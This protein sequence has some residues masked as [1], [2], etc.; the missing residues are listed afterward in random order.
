MPAPRLDVLTYTGIHRRLERD[1][2]K[3]SEFE[4]VGCGEPAQEWAYD[5]LDL[6]EA[7]RPLSMK[8]EHYHP[9]CI[10]CHRRFD[11]RDTCTKGHE[12]T[13]ENTYVYKGARQ[14]RRC[15][16]EAMRVLRSKR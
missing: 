10:S 9:M 3:A 15:R 13:E 16:R 5:H 12:F 11:K 4:C 8:V 1:R 7:G 14:C 2:G 6:D